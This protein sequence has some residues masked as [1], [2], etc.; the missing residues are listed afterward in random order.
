MHQYSQYQ[1]KSL[2]YHLMLTTEHNV[3]FHNNMQILFFCNFRTVCAS[4]I[5]EF[6]NVLFLF[7]K[8]STCSLSICIAEGICIKHCL[9]NIYNSFKCPC[10]IL[11]VFSSYKVVRKLISG[12]KTWELL[13]LFVFSRLCW[14]LGL[15]ITGVNVN[16][17]GKFL[18]LL[19][20]D[21]E[22][23]NYTNL[24]FSVLMSHVLYSLK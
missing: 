24:H 1:R 19:R 17:K 22:L 16:G 6:L 7:S 23:L 10:F 9:R 18:K 2:P 13:L 8:C 21:S 11:W 20:I 4:L 3:T 15:L 5:L 12:S 14:F